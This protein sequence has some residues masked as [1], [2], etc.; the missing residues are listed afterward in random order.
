[1]LQSDL[2]NE[3]HTYINM[4]K[5]ILDNCTGLN[6]ESMNLAVDK[7]INSTTNRIV[8]KQDLDIV[9][10]Q[11]DASRSS[12]VSSINSSICAFNIQKNILIE[13]TRNLQTSYRFMSDLSLKRQLFTV[14]RECTD[15]ISNI[16]SKIDILERKKNMLINHRYSLQTRSEYYDCDEYFDEHI[17]E[18]E[19]DEMYDPYFEE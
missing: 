5:A 3:A 1:M 2:T 12:I 13:T 6:I 16:L 18:E 11:I 7:W 9:E 14:H 17:N 15:M 8:Y 10:D 19:F 4:A